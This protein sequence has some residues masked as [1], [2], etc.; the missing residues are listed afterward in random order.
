MQLLVSVANDADAA[1]AIAGGADW[2]DAK[3]PAEGPLGRVTIAQLRR[4]CGMAGPPRAVSA[5]LGDLDDE[6]EIER[7]S[8]EYSQ[9]GPRLLKIGVGHAAT[10]ADV[11][12]L[13]ASAVKAVRERASQTTAIVAVAYADEGAWAG[14]PDQFVAAAAAA[15]ASGVLLDTARKEGPGLCA[16]LPLTL[17]TDW[18]SAAHEAGLSMAVA[19]RLTA[20][21]LPRL[22]SCGPDVA[23]VRGAACT[24]GR[25]G[26]VIAGNVMTLRAACLPRDPQAR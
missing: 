16:L 20:D 1:Q 6:M 18:V 5:A 10:S 14:K 4:I 7:L 23:G 12:R 22:A 15:G 2:I 3:D 24:G 26:S 21:D 11:T 25:R 9:P 13:T 8:A 17:I 19:G